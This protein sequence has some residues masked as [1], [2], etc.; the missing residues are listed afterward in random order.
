MTLEEFKAAILFYNPKAQFLEDGR[1][2][3]TACTP[4]AIPVVSGNFDHAVIIGHRSRI[5]GS[6]GEAIAHGG[7]FEAFRLP[8]APKRTRLMTPQECAG[9]WIMVKG[10][11]GRELIVG[12]D[13]AIDYVTTSRG[14]HFKVEKIHLLG[15]L[16]SDSPTSEPYS[17]EVE[18]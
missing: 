11:K 3:F 9:K 14:E 12:F 8:P 15:W 4:T 17:L 16:I 18:E 6:S 7:S 5:G 1:G 2:I 13:L 10:M